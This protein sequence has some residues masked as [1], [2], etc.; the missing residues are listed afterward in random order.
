M[1]S[2]RTMAAACALVALLVTVSAT[3]V[4]LNQPPPTSGS[5]AERQLT[6]GDASDLDPAFSP[7]GKRIAYSSDRDGSFDI[8][9]MSS[10]GR[11]QI[12]LT[13]MLGDER[14][15]KW[16]P[17]GSKVAFLATDR[18]KTDIWI[19]NTDG[20][21]AINLT[22]DEAVEESFEWSPGSD[23]LVYD[24]N[25]N[26]RWDIWIV[27][28]QAKHRALLTRGE[29]N[30]RYLCWSPDGRNILFSSDRSGDYDIWMM[31]MD[32]SRQ[33]RLTSNPGSDIK[34]RYS[35]DGK[36][37]TFLSG[38]EGRY[39]V[40]VMNADDSGVQQ[41]L[42]PPPWVLPGE[43]ARLVWS[44]DSTKILFHSALNADVDAGIILIDLNATI[45]FGE[46][47]GREFQ[48]YQG[49]WSN[50]LTTSW[51]REI[52]P[53][54]SQDGRFIIFQSDETERWGLRRIEF[55]VK[56]ERHGY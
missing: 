41:A 39:E 7:D 49:V 14:N 18:G 32:S 15:P 19:I 21:E 38:Q 10:D 17:D 40:W 37:I 23:L 27:D 29:G 22:D 26:G 11:R 34:A 56:V 47:S 13:S 42:V 36:R 43:E 4:S 25:K 55:I 48:I 31:N 35:P 20:S 2:S 53:S 8:W 28:S 51:A 12:R 50:R 46:P 1:A 45:I 44:S 52:N 16:S 3:V 24:S 33:I 6:F 54:W 9:I 5:T 30:N